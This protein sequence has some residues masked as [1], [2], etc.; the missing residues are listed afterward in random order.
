METN[1]TK[2]TLSCNKKTID[3]AKK[4]A[5]LNNES[6]SYIVS[7]FLETYISIN[8]NS[9]NHDHA[10]QEKIKLARKF[11]GSFHLGSSSDLKK[12]YF[13]SKARPVK[14]K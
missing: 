6:V 2:L 1:K 13:E 10:V 14:N 7:E 4:Y 9:K 11:S 8:K 3:E 5:E 12:E